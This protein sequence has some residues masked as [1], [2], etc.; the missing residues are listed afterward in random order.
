MTDTARRGAGAADAL[1]WL[2]LTALL[3]SGLALQERAAGPTIFELTRAPTPLWAK[4]AHAVAPSFLLLAA[5]LS[6]FLRISAEAPPLSERVAGSAAA[7][8]VLLGVFLEAVGPGAGVGEPSFWIGQALGLDLH[9]TM[10]AGMLLAMGLT[11]AG[12]TMGLQTTR[13]ET[14]PPRP[15]LLLTAALGAGLL[16]TAAAMTF[17]IAGDA[18]PYLRPIIDWSTPAWYSLPAYATARAGPTIEFGVATM[19]ALAGGVLLAPWTGLGRA[20]AGSPLRLLRQALFG[21]AVLSVL[22]LGWLG[23]VT[24][25][26][27]SVQ[28]GMEGPFGLE[29]DVAQM[30]GLGLTAYLLT[31]LWILRP[32]LGLIA[33]ATAAPETPDPAIF[34]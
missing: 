1:V 4:L 7:L 13:R 12:M 29:T 8:V 14:P 21:G 25:P 5:L 19:L 16:I 27:S 2:G 3:I 9:A 22:I 18:N 20:R 11:R 24:P 32:T 30:V 34:S 28:S 6:L 10:A 33:K 26:V 17:T 31:Y 23:A 15:G